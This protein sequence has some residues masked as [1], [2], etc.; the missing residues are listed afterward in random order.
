MVGHGISEPSTVALGEVSFRF[1]KAKGE[2]IGSSYASAMNAMHLGS[3][4]DGMDFLRYLDGFPG[5]S[6]YFFVEL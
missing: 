2:K 3:K 6:F 1:I 5:G 4:L